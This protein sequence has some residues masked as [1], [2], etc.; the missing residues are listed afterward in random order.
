MT[1]PATLATDRCLE[2][3]TGHSRGLATAAEET[4]RK[5]VQHCPGW[6]LADLVWHVTEVHWF[7]RTIVAELLPE[8]PED[9]RRPPRP[10]DDEL[11]DTFLAGADALV[12]TLRAASQP[13]RCWTWFPPQQ[14]V[15]FV[16]RHQV[17]EAGVHHWDA[18]NAVGRPLAIAPDLAADSI[19]EFLT[20]SVADVDEAAR[21]HSRDHT[22]LGG[23]LVL[24]AVDTEQW[25]TV[26]QDGPRAPLLWTPQ[27]GDPV[28]EGT[29]SDLLLWLYH[30]AELPATNKNLV[31]RF[32]RLSS[33]D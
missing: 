4:L 2:A 24:H 3:I 10:P 32:R 30:R 9:T 15:A 31:N 33:T 6:N 20:T 14:D 8:P 12:E 28:V 18:A 26:T 1:S 19:S 17:Q 7:W 21:I 11:L 29:T 27:P 22:Q 5:R 13:A 25:W 16:T 23:D